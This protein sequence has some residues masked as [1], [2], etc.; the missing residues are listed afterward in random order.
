[1]STVAINVG[2]FRNHE[3]ALGCRLYRSGEEFPLG[4]KGA[5]EQRLSITGDV[6]ACTFSGVS[7]G[8]YAVSVMHDEN[9]SG[10]LDP[11]F[12]GIPSEGYGVSNNHTHAMSE[13]T[14]DEST[15]TVEAGRD[16]RLG[17]GLRY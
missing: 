10:K 12:L 4:S 8:T 15:F 3:G 16:V 14:W 13:P 9:G 1:M 17:V 11:N 7:P 6:T 2:T 5:V